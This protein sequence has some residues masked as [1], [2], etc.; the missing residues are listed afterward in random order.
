MGALLYDGARIEFDDRTL[1]HLQV[2]IVGRIRRGESVLV[3]WLDALADGDGRTA[4]WI[5]AALPVRF[6]FADAHLPEID[7]AWIARLNAGAASRT[8]LMV[9]DVQ[10][11]PVRPIHSTI[12]TP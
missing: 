7:R 4:I 11:R 10:G 5:D 8:G 6:E 3:G 1:A 2:V 9:E 12:H